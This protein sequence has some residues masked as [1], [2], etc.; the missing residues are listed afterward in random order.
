MVAGA[1]LATATLPPGVEEPPKEV[2]V[3]VQPP[4]AAC[5]AGLPGCALGLL[6]PGAGPTVTRSGALASLERG[7]VRQANLGGV[8][9]GPRLVRV[10]RAPARVTFYVTLPPPGRSHNVSRYPVAVVGPGWSG[11][12]VSDRT[13]IPGLLSVADIAPA[14]RAIGGGK[15]PEELHARGDPNPQET[16]RRLDDR[17]TAAHHARGWANAVLVVITLG[18]AAAAVLLRLSALARAA[19]LTP[20]ALLLTALVLSAAHVE[21]AWL[22]TLTLLLGGGATAVAA[23]LDRRLL[24]WFV[25]AFLAA[26]LLV[27]SAWPTVNSFAAL[28]PHPDGGG[29]FYGITN[30]V[31]TLLVAPVI[32]AAATLPERFLLPFALLA[33]VAVGWSQAGA[34]GGG[35][36]VLLAGLAVLA[37]RLRGD[38]LEPRRLAL[39]GAG[40]AA[41]VFGLV[42][43]DVAT[44]GSSH[45]TDAITDGPRSLIGDFAHRVEVSWAGATSSWHS[46]LLVLLCLG[47][48]AWLG[49]RTP[50]RPTVDA[51][52]VALGVSLLVNDTP[53]DVFAYGA[54][55]CATLFA[56][57]RRS[58]RRDY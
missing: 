43:V 55:G 33:L 21:S 8:P 29:R 58:L 45:V 46:I 36:V 30:Q 41:A 50:R 39:A 38:R 37:F 9:T 27:L 1:M 15:E 20:P 11:L 18:L 12:L 14:A 52:L 3:L 16:M 31:G 4:P 40:V 22:V 35:V 24:P 10:S 54:L 13:R 57:E 34:D 44:G 51:L 53:L 26:E 42:A 2:A 17:L 28:G 6:V 49:T 19:V 47:V 23:G 48:L 7:K 56:W 25:V 5:L 32:A